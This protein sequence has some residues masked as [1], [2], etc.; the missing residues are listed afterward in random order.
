MRVLAIDTSSAVSVLSLVE[1]SR[2]LAS[3]AQ[4]TEQ[5]HAET[6]LPRIAAMLEATGHRLSSVELIAVGLGPGSFTGLRVG[7]A[8]AKGLALATAIPLRGVHS[9]QALARGALQHA[10]VALA[11]AD[12]GRG[13]VLGAAYERAAD[14]RLRAV[15]APLLATPDRF[16]AAFAASGCT[17][18]AA[19]GQGA[20]RYW[21]AFAGLQG[22][23]ELGPPEADAPGAEHIAQEAL[24]ALRDEGPSSVSGLEPLYTRG[25]DAKLPDQPLSLD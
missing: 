16:A 11:V 23:L 7:L 17:R 2:V 24:I 12:A 4:S 10:D 8:T 9:L 6:L 1:G 25:S 15:L 5:R 20:R 19:C 13:E 18:A 3:D 22:A 14:G 21:S